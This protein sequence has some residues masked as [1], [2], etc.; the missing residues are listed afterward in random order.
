MAFNASGLELSGYLLGSVSH[1]SLWDYTTADNIADVQVSNYF[2]DA[3]EMIRV[4]D[5]IRVTAADGKAMYI[6]AHVNP[7]SSPKQATITKL[8]T[9]TSFP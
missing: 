2:G 1:P 4:S 9:A 6:I 7:G 3:Y 5:L 8:A